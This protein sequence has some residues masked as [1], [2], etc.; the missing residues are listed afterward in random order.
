MADMATQNGVVWNN[1]QPSCNNPYI[2]PESLDAPLTEKGR[3]QALHHQPVIDAMNQKPQLIVVSFNCR[4]LQ[5]AVLVFE[6]LVK[7]HSIP[8]LAR[9][10]AREECGVHLCDMR[11]PKSRQAFEF[12]QVDFSLLDSELDPLHTTCCETKQQVA[13]RIYRFM[14]WLY[15]RREN[16]I[17]VVSHL[18]WLLT[19]FNGICDCQDPA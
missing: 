11:R 18:G 3:Q 1:F 12:P 4:A 7:E 2:L 13:E 14:T 19:L 8:C 17:A 15:T 16:S 9:E 5:T 10:M 6:A